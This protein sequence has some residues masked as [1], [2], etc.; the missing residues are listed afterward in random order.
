M[1]R[2]IVYAMYEASLSWCEIILVTYAIFSKREGKLQEKK[3]YKKKYN[4]EMRGNATFNGFGEISFF[5]PSFF[6]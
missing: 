1:F 3:I 5:F 4:N 6:G 2:Q